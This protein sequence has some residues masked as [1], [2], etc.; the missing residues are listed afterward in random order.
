[1]QEKALAWIVS[2]LDEKEIPYSICGGLAA[3]FYGSE[4][5]LNDIDLFVPESYFDGVVESCAGYIS[6]PAQHYC[7]A[8]EGWDLV[9]AQFIF[10]GTKIEV[11]NASN[12]RIYDASSSCW[13]T[14]NI[15]FQNTVRG[16]LL[17]TEV[18]VM[19]MADLIHYKRLL[20]RA[21]DQQDV[22]MLNGGRDSL[23]R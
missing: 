2:I 14:L 4:R 6:K 3:N 1:M 18:S 11:G 20:N 13:H 22:L 12:A 19:P 5:P 21:V 23:P 8:A 10:A 17:G 9:Y 15:D 16:E 7:E